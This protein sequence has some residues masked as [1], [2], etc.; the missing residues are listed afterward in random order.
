MCSNYEEKLTMLLNILRE[1]KMKAYAIKYQLLRIKTQY[2]FEPIKYD[3]SQNTLLLKLLITISGKLINYVNKIKQCVLLISLK[4]IKRQ[5]IN[6]IEESKN[7]SYITNSY[8]CKLGMTGIEFYYT[9]PKLYEY[10]LDCS[11]SNENWI[12]NYEII[13]YLLRNICNRCIENFEIIENKLQII[14]LHGNRS[15][16]DIAYLHKEVENLEKTLDDEQMTCIELLNELSREDHDKATKF[17]KNK[18]VEYSSILAKLDRVN[19]TQKARLE[20][21][22]VKLNA[23]EKR[24]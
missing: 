16:A 6:I 1:W 22:K 23:L 2:L 19:K 21:N 20:L 8:F 4:S 24:W 11:L 9:M 12:Y 15:R 13:N 3:S 14:E 18:Q 17:T 5:T 7:I 10:R